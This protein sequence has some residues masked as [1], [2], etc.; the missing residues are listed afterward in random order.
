MLG[1]PGAA[2]PNAAVSAALTLADL[3]RSHHA[4]VYQWLKALWAPSKV[5]AMFTD[6]AGRRCL[7]S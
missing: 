2:L 7:T 4:L 6:S 1:L 3:G 5:M